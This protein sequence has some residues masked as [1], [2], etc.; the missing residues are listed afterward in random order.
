MT[1]TSLRAA[2]SAKQARSN[3][4]ERK[5]KVRLAFRSVDIGI[6]REID[7][8]IGT[9]VPQGPFHAAG[10]ADVEPGAADRKGCD[11][12]ARGRN[13]HESARDLSVPAGCKYPHDEVPGSVRAVPGCYRKGALR[14]KSTDFGHPRCDGLG[15]L[16]G[17]CLQGSPDACEHSVNIDEDNAIVQERPL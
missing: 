16:F 7:Q 8:N 5:S 4:V 3:S 12:L 1:G 14:V 13:L 15:I 17:L 10:L 11:V 9:N 2:A 6:A